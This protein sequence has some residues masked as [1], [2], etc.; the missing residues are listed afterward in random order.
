[1][2]ILRTACAPIPPIYTRLVRSR[3]PTLP[4]H[5]TC[6]ATCAPVQRLDVD[7]RKTPPLLPVANLRGTSALPPTEEERSNLCI[8]AFRAAFVPHWS[9][10]RECPPRNK[11]RQGP[12]R[13]V[14]DRR[15]AIPDQE[16]HPRTPRSKMFPNHSSLARPTRLPK[17][18]STRNLK[19]RVVALATRASNQP[20][21]KCARDIH[22]PSRGESLTLRKPS[23]AC[24]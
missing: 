2:V 1:M 5:P 16:V 3:C 6:C 23:R 17:S 15:R 10:D 7:N 8:A 13:R 24:P 9:P 19:L 18:R 4:R 12:F 20:S 11:S 22:R 21:N 14:R